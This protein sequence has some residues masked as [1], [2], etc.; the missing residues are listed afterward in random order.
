MRR[1]SLVT[2][3]SIAALAVVAVSACSSAASSGA[4]AGQS[5]STSAGTNSN[6]TSSPLQAGLAAYEKEPASIGPAPKLTKAPP[7][8][9]TFVQISNGAG[10]DQSTTKGLAAATATVGWHLKTLQANLTDPSTTL[11]ALIT[12]INSGANFVQVG[13][14]PMAVW[15]SAIPLARAHH[16]VIIDT[17]GSENPRTQPAPD[18]V[19]YLQNGVT[20]QTLTGKVIMD[21]ALAD[22]G[23]SAKASF[24]TTEVPQLGAEATAFTASARAEMHSKCPSCQL[25]TVQI[26]FGDILAGKGAQ[27]VIAYL[28]THPG[29]KYVLIAQGQAVTGLARA[30][31]A[32]G[33]P[34]VKIY[35]SLPGPDELQGLS[36]GDY[37]AWLQ[38][39]LE[40]FGWE[41]IDV[42]LRYA[43][44][45]KTYAWAPTLWLLTKNNI[46]Q[47]SNLTDPN[48]PGDFESQFKALWGVK[49]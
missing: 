36:T 5:A 42:S 13:A 19:I 31:Q 20:L 3:V 4:N 43:I 8:G 30:V 21:V 1:S 9:M 7:A 49:G 16:T 15:Q 38:T 41:S 46:N 27:D 10:Y 18:G 47:V 32:A 48:F 34:A 2:S 6:G 26:P 29:T 37:Q 28:Q 25:G 24:V 45:D 11:S 40:V 22:A 14:T 12:A 35:G 17:A 23:T 44:G 33:L 39:P